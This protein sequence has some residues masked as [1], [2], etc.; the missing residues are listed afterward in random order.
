LPAP[1][2]ERLKARG[3]YLDGNEMQRLG[4]FAKV[5]AVLYPK[6]GSVWRWPQATAIEA[7]SQCVSVRF[8]TG[9][10][11]CY[12]IAW[13][14]AGIV[15]RPYLQCEYCN[16]PRVKLFASLGC[17]ACRECIRAKYTS[18]QIGNE[19]RRRLKRK[20]LLAECNVHHD[21]GGIVRKPRLMWRRSFR[22]IRYQIDQIER[23]LS[24]QW[25]RS[26]SRL[27]WRVLPR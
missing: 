20:A 8:I 26:H 18:N 19:K 2:V 21:C 15:W 7:N 17:F 24:T 27:T 13:K 6:D 3:D 5:R 4:L 14:Q 16:K 12:Q 10:V 22:R 25:R 9:R 1:T 11:G 23:Q